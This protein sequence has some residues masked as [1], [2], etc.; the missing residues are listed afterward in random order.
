MPANISAGV[1]YNSSG[2]I[3]YLQPDA[4]PIPWV[5]SCSAAA[6]FASQ[7]ASDISA[8]IYGSWI[9]DPLPCAARSSSSSSSSSSSNP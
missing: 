9:Q 8:G 7:D 4:K 6:R 5:E 3:M 2:Q 1:L